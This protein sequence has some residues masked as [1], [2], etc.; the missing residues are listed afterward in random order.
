M[1]LSEFW[2]IFLKIVQYTSAFMSVSLNCILIFLILAHSPKKLGMYKYLMIYISSFEALYSL[3]D[4]TTEPMVH[5]YKAAFVV[6]RNFKN[7]DFDREHSFILIVIYCGCFGFSLAIFGV[8]F[9]YRYGAVVKE[10]RDKW[11]GGKK[12]YI[13]FFM[14]IF[15]GTWWSV[16]C[17][18]YFH[19]DD[20]TDD[21]MRKTIFDGYDTKIEDTSYIIVLFHPVDKNGTSHPDPAVFASIACM[22]FMILSSVFSVFFFGIKC[23]FRITEALSRTCN[24]SSVTKGLQQQLFQ[25]LVVQTFIPLIL[26]YIPIAILFT[27]PMIAVDIGFASSFVAMTIAVYPAIDPLPNMFIIKNYRKAVFAFFSAIF[28]NPCGSIRRAQC[29]QIELVSKSETPKNIGL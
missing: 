10:F 11:L 26:M 25:A 22:W 18:L 3:W 4:V 14:P 15:Y 13:L 16:L 6:F 9:V 19:F 7:S 21:Y 17:Y 1:H 27:F 29:T 5:S 28:R 2:N 24:V 8:H 12:I 20:S 23:Y